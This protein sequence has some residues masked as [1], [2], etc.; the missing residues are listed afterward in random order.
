[1]LFLPHQVMYMDASAS[2]E[3]TRDEMMGIDI[4]DIKPDDFLRMQMAM[5]DLVRRRA[6]AKPRSR[7]S[8]KTDCR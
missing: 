2:Y 8:A 5:T 6:R 7:I 4:S 1:M 3:R